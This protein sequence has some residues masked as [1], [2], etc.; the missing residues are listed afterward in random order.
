MQIVLKRKKEKKEKKGRGGE[1]HITLNWPSISS[2]RDDVTADSLEF[3]PELPLPVFASI[4]NK[5]LDSLST[6]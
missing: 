4:C 1:H 3:S 6:V 5:S 2:L